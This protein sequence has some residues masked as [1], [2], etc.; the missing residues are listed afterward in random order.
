MLLPRVIPI[1]LLKETGIV[2]GARFKSHQYIGDPLNAVHL[3]NSKEVDELAILDI[4]AT[5][6]NRAISSQFVS[7]IANEC[8]MPLMVGGGISSLA[9]ASELLAAGAEKITINSHWISNPQLISDIA[10]KFG[11]QSVVVS[12]DV[13]KNWLGKYFAYTHNGHQRVKT[14]PVQLA[15]MAESLGAGEL[16]VNAIHCDGRMEGYD[17]TLLSSIS[18]AVNIPVIAAGGAGNLQHFQDVIYQGNCAAAAASSFFVFHGRRRAVLISYPNRAE[19]EVIF[20]VN[21]SKA[22]E[23]I[24]VL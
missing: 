10:K 2:K 24:N 17:I 16:L 1:L 20:S 12:I 5:K 23:R 15:K 9:Q 7:Q 21:N 3:F 19:M 11:T 6:N 22:I 8:M 4:T 13:N 18:S 14:K